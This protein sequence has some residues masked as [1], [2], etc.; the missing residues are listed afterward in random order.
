MIDLVKLK[1]VCAH[2]ANC[3]SVGHQPNA[4]QAFEQLWNDFLKDGQLTKFYGYRHSPAYTVMPSELITGQPGL[5]WTK[6]GE[7]VPFNG[8]ERG[9]SQ[10]STPFIPCLV[11]ACHPDVPDGGVVETLRWVRDKN[12][13]DRD[14]MRHNWKF[15]PPYVITHFCDKINIPV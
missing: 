7:R 8:D 11:Y 4:W 3:I 13:W 15:D 5:K 12:D 1:L 14:A 10:M 9:P 2:F 6:V